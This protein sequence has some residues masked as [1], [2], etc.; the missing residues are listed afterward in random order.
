EKSASPASAEVGDTITY[1]VTTTVANATTDAVFTLTDTLGTGLAL[2]TVTAPGDYTCNATNPLECTL[3][4]GTTPGTYV[5]EYTTTVTPDAGDTVANSVVGAG[6]GGDD[7]EC[8]ADCD[9]ET[10]ITEPVI[11]FNKVADVSEVSIGDTVTYTVTVNVADAALS[12]TFTLEDT[13]GTGLTFDAV[14]GG[15]STEFSCSPGNPLFCTLPVGTS[16]GTYTLIYTVAVNSNALEQVSNAVT[17][18]GGGGDDPQCEIDCDIDLPVTP[19]IS[20][21]KSATP[22]F[23]EVGDIIT[24]TVTTTVANATTDA[25][26]T[27]TDTLG[28]GLALDA[29]TAPGDYTCNA[30]NPLECTLP[31]GTTPGTYVLEYTATVTPDAGDTVANSVVGAGGGDD[32]PECSADCDIETP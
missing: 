25:V 15:T 10:P 17:G 11:T 9:I 32:E 2:D 14:D 26:F 4:P 18:T 23:V 31:S 27:L 7:P 12:E 16:T 29:V 20:Y 6:G 19:E 13:L 24:Y 28:I 8:S 3:P 1:T 30:A 22:A 21:E 5:L